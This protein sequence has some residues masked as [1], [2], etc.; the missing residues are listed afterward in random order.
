[1]RRMVTAVV[2]RTQQAMLTLG[3]VLGVASVVLTVAAPLVHVRPLIFLSGSMSPTITTGS[4]GLARTTPA[5]DLRV[6]DVVTVPA[7]DN[8]YITHRIV[9]ITHHDSAATLRLKGDANRQADPA[10]HEI[11]EAPRVF[12]AVPYAG[13]VVA[14]FSRAPG[15]YVLAAY[16]VCALGAL[17]RRRE[18]LRRDRDGGEGSSGDDAQPPADDGGAGPG[19]PTVRSR[20]V[21]VRPGRKTAAAAAGV[22]AS[23]AVAAPAQ[24]FFLDPVPVTGTTLSAVNGTAPVVTCGASAGQ[25]ITLNW[26]SVPDATGYRLYSDVGGSTTQDVSASTNSVTYANKASGTFF[27]K[28]FYGSTTWLSPASNSKTYESLG[29]G[30][31]S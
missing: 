25:S 23:I 14:W 27:V 11:L 24:A 1:M 9:E 20:G 30:S 16:V 15:V 29:Q 19:V 6:G 4:L 7:G 10:V 5:A 31:C 8:T 13:S 18:Q 17:R 22:A 21:R 2:R 28:A 3:A 26:T 12:A